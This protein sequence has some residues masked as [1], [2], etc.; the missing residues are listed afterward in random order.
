[1]N[2]R[3]AAYRIFTPNS[4][5]SAPPNTRDIE[6]KDIPVKHGPW[7]V[8]Q[9]VDPVRGHMQPGADT[10][11]CL[12]NIEQSEFHMTDAHVPNA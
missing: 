11:Q 8:F 1:M 9:S 10:D 4:R 6:G 3:S 5:P 7:A 2:E 12:G